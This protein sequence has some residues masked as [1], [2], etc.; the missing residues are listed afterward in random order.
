[1]VVEY[2]AIPLDRGAETDCVGSESSWSSAV[3]RCPRLPAPGRQSRACRNIR[4]MRSLPARR[5]G[6]ALGAAFRQTAS[7]L[8]ATRRAPPRTRPGRSGLC[9]TDRSQ[10]ARAGGQPLEVL[11]RQSV[12][13]GVWRDAARLHHAPADRTCQG[14][15]AGGQPHDHRDLPAGRLRKPGQLQLALSRAGRSHS[16]RLP[17]PAH[18]AGGGPAPIPGCF[19][20]MWTRPAA[21]SEQSGR[22]A[23]GG[24]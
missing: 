17:A 12:R 23:S 20:L 13:R 3:V 19:V 24:S 15:A 5:A 8:R 6:K 16:L 18:T 2:A 4:R 22:C 7:W 10:R 14:S 9:Q 11:F 21:E 1:M